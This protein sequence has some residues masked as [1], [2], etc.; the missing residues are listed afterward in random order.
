MRTIEELEQDNNRLREELSV[1][2]W[3]VKDI[4]VML[5]RFMEADLQHRVNLAVASARE[6][7]KVV[8]IEGEPIEELDLTARTNNV[9]KGN[10]IYTVEQL[11]T[12]SEEDLWKLEL[13]GR[14]ALNEIKEVLA[15]RGLSLRGRYE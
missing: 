1:L 4:Y 2:F 7:Y 11:V 12:Y 8:K 3:K 15:S 5:E 6:K 14:K 10:S 9:L 13:L